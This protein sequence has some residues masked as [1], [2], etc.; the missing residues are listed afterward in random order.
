MVANVNIFQNYDHVA[1][2]T[3]MLISGSWLLWFTQDDDNTEIYHAPLNQYD[4]IYTPK[5]SPHACFTNAWYEQVSSTNT[6]REQQKEIKIVHTLVAR[7]M[8]ISPHDVCTREEEV[9][10]GTSMPPLPCMHA[11]QLVLPV[12][13]NIYEYILSR[14]SRSWFAIHGSNTQHTFACFDHRCL[15]FIRGLHSIEFLLKQIYCI[16]SH[17]SEP[18]SYHDRRH[19]PMARHKLMS[20]LHG[21][22]QQ[23]TPIRE[24]LQQVYYKTTL[25]THTH[26]SLLQ[27]TNIGRQA[28]VSR[29]D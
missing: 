14:A 18:C 19:R 25:I 13:Q 15:C 10:R 7:T 3:E 4:L 20:V 26:T 17:A 27:W 8:I 29:L 24:W 6:T 16:S 22:T 9:K 5:I 12:N 21:S 28:N 11:S 1:Q 2:N 23:M